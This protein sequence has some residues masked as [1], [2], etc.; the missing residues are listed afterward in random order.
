MTSE[1]QQGER[2]LTSTVTNAAE[3]NGPV[4]FVSAFLGSVT[5]EAYVLM[6]AS[7]KSLVVMDPEMVF[8]STNN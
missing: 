3:G 1:R 5:V 7:A 8:V 2:G 6:V 4:Y